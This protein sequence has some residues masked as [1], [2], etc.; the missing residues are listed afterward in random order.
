MK[1][2]VIDHY[3]GRRFSLLTQHGK[4]QVVAPT[5]LTTLNARIELAQGFDTDTFGT[6]TRDVP[7][8]GSQLRAAR[9]KAKKGME[10]TGCSF[11]IAS[12]GSFGPAPFGWIPWNVEIVVLVDAVRNIEIVGSA[13]GPASHHH[14]LVSTVEELRLFST[15]AG[16]PE[17]GLVVR[18]EGAD[19]PRLRK[20]L[21]SLAALDEAFLAAKAQSS[22][23]KVHVESDLRADMNPT[24]MEI[25]RR[26]TEDLVRRMK[27][28]CPLCHSP[29]YWVAERIPGLACSD[30]GAPTHE[31][32]AERWA[33]VAG[34]HTEQ[35]PSTKPAADPGNCSECNP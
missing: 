17:H 20:G 34:D 29:G 11:G 27:S 14:E 35:R 32:R 9:E 6:F 22:T 5:F 15:R 4:E 21:R 23:G 18:P 25:I 2:Y 12:E 24:R 13:S 10:L 28:Q 7:R 26:A 8:T 19:D 3:S 16:F 33:C 30:C 31:V 1:P